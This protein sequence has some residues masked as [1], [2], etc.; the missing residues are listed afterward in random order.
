MNGTH[1]VYLISFHLFLFC[2][3]PVKAKEKNADNTIVASLVL[4]F[5]SVPNPS[6]KSSVNDLQECE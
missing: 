3:G 5:P 2:S 4:S 6:T 1:F